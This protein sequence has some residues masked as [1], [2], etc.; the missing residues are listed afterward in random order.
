MKVNRKR[1]YVQATVAVYN[2]E[3]YWFTSRQDK[4]Q[5]AGRWFY[6]VGD[7]LKIV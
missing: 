6:P 5:V 7:Y 1:L 2:S 3:G 4:K